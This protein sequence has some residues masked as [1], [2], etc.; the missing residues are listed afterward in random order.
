ME[1][2]APPFFSLL[3]RP[4]LYIVHVLFFFHSPSA[5]PRPLSLFLSFSCGRAVSVLLAFVSFFFVFFFYCVVMRVCVGVRICL[6]YAWLAWR[7]FRCTKEGRE[8]AF[9]F[10]PFVA[11]PLSLSPYFAF[12][13]SAPF[14]FLCLFIVV[15]VVV[16]CF[17]GSCDAF[18]HRLF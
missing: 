13:L 6:Y 3:R 7:S 18:S 16:V 15:A 4:C 14:F 11:A 5:F 10:S 8:R 9:I 12:P 17:E 1:N 2:C